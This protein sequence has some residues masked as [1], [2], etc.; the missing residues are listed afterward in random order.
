MAVENLTSDSPDPLVLARL[1][2]LLAA[3]NGAVFEVR[4]DFTIADWNPA[5]ERMY[6]YTR[7]EVLN[8]PLS[9]VIGDGAQALCSAL[10]LVWEQGSSEPLD[11]DHLDRSGGLVPVVMRFYP[12]PAP[13][14][15]IQ[16]CYVVASDRNADSRAATR[17]RS[18]VR[19]LI[20]AQEEE[21]RRIAYDLH[22]GLTQYVM[23]SHAHL[24]TF[25]HAHE[26]G[27]MDR[28]ATELDHGIQYLKEAI[29]ESRRLVNGLRTLALDNMGLGGALEQLLNEEKVRAG[30]SEAILVNYVTSKLDK[31][32]TT[33]LFRITQEALTNARKHARADRVRIMLLENAAPKSVDSHI[34]LEVRDW[35]R[36]FDTTVPIDTN[37]HVGLQSMQERARLLN[38]TLSLQSMHGSGTVIRAV[39]PVIRPTDTESSGELP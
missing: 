31:V 22:D 36:G 17:Q 33:A 14:G 34:T 29:I 39:F 12:I 23:A 15:E 13:T 37:A 28:A 16:A 20:A 18:L 27:R 9:L 6:G 4:P 25:R 2:S 3:H 8:R 24:E 35:G 5:A 21:R 26:T 30:W 32:L 7:A 19:A 1:T 11:A 38:G 10:G